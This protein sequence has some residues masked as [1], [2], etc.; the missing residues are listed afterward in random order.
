LTGL[1]RV[2]G[3]LFKI[4]YL[5]QIAQDDSSSFRLKLW[6]YISDVWNI[7]DV[8]TMLLFLT[9]MILRAIPDNT[10][11]FRAARIVLSINLLTFYLRLLHIFSVFKQLGPVLVMIGRMV[12]GEL[13]CLVFE[14]VEVIEFVCMAAPPPQ[15]PLKPQNPGQINK[16]VQFSPK[17]SGTIDPQPSQFQHPCEVFFAF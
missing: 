5:F 2:I 17:T 14:S 10:S 4:F 13:K 7:L 3:Q 11:T 16:M 12:S 1:G 15:F 6:S 9:G 8:I